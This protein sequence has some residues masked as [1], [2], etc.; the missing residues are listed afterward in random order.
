MKSNKTFLGYFALFL[1]I[2]L[3]MAGVAIVSPANAASDVIVIGTTDSITNLDP[4]D[5]YDYF[6]SN[7]LVQIT[8]GLMEMPVDSTDAVKGPMIEEYTVSSDAKTYTFKLKTGIKYSDGEAFDAA[9][10]V[11][12]LQRA[13]DLGGD[14]SFLLSDVVDTVTA[15][16]D[17]TVKI[18]LQKP[19]A[20][21]LQRLTYTV[22]WPVSPKSLPQNAIA[23]DPENIPAGLGPYKITSWTKG[24]ELILE[25]NDNYF[26]DAPA[27]K[28][29]IIK[30]YSD[31][32]ALLTAL[33]TGEIDV[34]HRQFG[35]E[36]IKEVMSLPGVEYQTKDTAGIRYLIVNVDAH[37]DQNVR[38]AIAAA[39]N[40]K[41]ITSTVFDDLNDP[42]YSMVPTIFSSHV[43][44][45]MDGP[46]QA[47]VEGN[48]TAAGYSTTNKYPITL[49]WTPSHYGTTE[50]DVASL[51]KQHLEDTGY[52]TVTLKSAEW[53]TYVGQLS[54][55]GFFLLGWWFD[56]PDPSNYIDPFVGS[57][58]FSLGTNYSSTQMDDYINT[59]LTNTDPN[60]RKEAIINAQKL[61]AEDVP[62]VPLFTMI[63]QFVAYQEGVTGV[64]L[65][66]SEN[67]HYNTITYGGEKGGFLAVSPLIPMLALL[68]I[69]TVYRLVVKPK[70]R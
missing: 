38:Q 42:L 24:T 40:R 12:N 28:K 2:W 47:D 60:T 36:E 52:F 27:N 32:S 48:M 33:K 45:F 30:F 44:A 50:S 10:V 19:D 11:W 5:A 18:T 59:M 53:S 41:D 64:V 23:G 22:A 8:H 17:T 25:P 26:G 51:I 16:D 6:S 63:K 46:V 69:V 29:V 67:L 7:T 9:S 15:V 31:A 49:W 1:A 55:M 3:T 70:R 61:I 43:D 66:P 56:Y 62:L 20:T 39:I 54:S 34:A 13:I 21:F 14:P 68:S 37:P 4:A 57:G 65:E 35:P 58:A